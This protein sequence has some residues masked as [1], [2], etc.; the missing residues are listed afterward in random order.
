MPT[1][2]SAV[3]VVCL[4]LEQYFYLNAHLTQNTKTVVI[5]AP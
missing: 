2:G 5:V 1:S 4:M 3:F